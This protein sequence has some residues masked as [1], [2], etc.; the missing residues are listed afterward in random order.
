MNEGIRK[1]ME[2]SKTDAEFRK[3]VRAAIDAYS[4][5]RTEEAVFSN[6]FVPVAAEYGVTAT[7][8]D[9]KEYLESQNDSELSDEETVQIAGGE[10]KT[11]PYQPLCTQTG[12]GRPV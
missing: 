2:R 6:I 5:E 8:E 12:M 10:D 11:E 7:F 4:G 1:L 9:F 3:K